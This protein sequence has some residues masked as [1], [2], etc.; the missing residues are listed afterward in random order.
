ML[1]TMSPVEDRR[2]DSMQWAIFDLLGGAPLNVLLTRS[3]ISFLFS[4]LCPVRH[5][6]SLL[7]LVRHFTSLL[8]PVRRFISLL[9][10][11]P[12]FHFSTK[13]GWSFHFSRYQASASLALRA[14]G[15]SEEPTAQM[16]W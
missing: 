7:D 9:K 1:E 4:L 8:N 14:A 12:S 3:V 16:L 5:L 2:G 10:P 11:G 13:P 15:T 6:T